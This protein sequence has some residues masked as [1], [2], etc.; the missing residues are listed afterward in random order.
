MNDTGRADPGGSCL[1]ALRARAVLPP[2]CLSKDDQKM[3][4]NTRKRLMLALC[5]V[6]ALGV[7]GYGTWWFLTGRY[8]QSTDNAYVEAEIVHIA[9]KVE[10]YVAKVAVQDNQAVKQG[11][12]LL[13]LDDSDYRAKLAEAEALLASRLGMAHSIQESLKGQQLSIEEAQAG[14]ASARAD[15]ERA[16][17][18]R[19][20]YANLAEAKW[21]ST[22]KL[23]SVVASAAQ[24]RASVAEKQAKL[25]ATTQQLNVLRAQV[26]A[27]GGNIR[28]AE[29]QVEEARL[30]L[31]YTEVRAPRDGV[32]GNRSAR[33]GQ[34]VRPGSTVMALVPLGDVYVVAN[35]KETQ[36]TRV[37]VGQPATLEVDAFP[38]VE[39]RGRVESIAPASGS[40]FSLLPP[41]NATG[42]FTKIV[43]RMPVK[44]ALERPLPE[45]V[46]LAPGMS[47]V[48]TIDTGKAAAPAPARKGKGERAEGAALAAAGTG[49]AVAGGAEPAAVAVVGVSHE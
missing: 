47:V 3:R 34:Y 29:A 39:L 19:Q 6:V 13:K 26:D 25:G 11:D 33:V 17:K 7:A 42:N 18:D 1:V 37:R 31:S 16:E 40:R 41:E 4:E 23:E 36:L 14:L 22:Q 2:R 9:P 32:I 21:V 48:A 28:Q 38:G 35:Y 45:G 46:R 24:A 15:A 10:G 27:V 49:T 43:Q 20:R 5:A 30:A 44:I 12:L 8:H